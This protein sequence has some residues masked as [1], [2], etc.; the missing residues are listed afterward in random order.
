[1]TDTVIAQNLHSAMIDELENSHYARGVMKECF[2]AAKSN[3]YQLELIL[4]S[5]EKGRIACKGESQIPQ[6]TEGVYTAE[7]VLSYSLESPFFYLNKQ[8]TIA[9]YAR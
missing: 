2:S 9:G 4:Y 6:S 1:M 5:T 8:Q 7:V 3:G